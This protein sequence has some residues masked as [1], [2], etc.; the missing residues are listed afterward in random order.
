[1]QRLLDAERAGEVNRATVELLGDAVETYLTIGAEDR[2]A[3]QR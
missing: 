1:L 2:A 3:W